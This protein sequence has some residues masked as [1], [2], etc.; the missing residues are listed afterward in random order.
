MLSAQAIKTIAGCLA[1]ILLML[2]IAGLSSLDSA[3][4]ETFSTI[5][6]GVVLPPESLELPNT[7]SS[8]DVISDITSAENVASASEIS[9][10]PVE[11]DY[12]KIEIKSETQVA[13]KNSA[14]AQKEDP[15]N[16]KNNMGSGGVNNDSNRRT[17]PLLQILPLLRALPFPHCPLSLKEPER[18]LHSLRKKL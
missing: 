8:S 4:E 15:M 18:L 10:A 6:S 3:A 13:G 9:S 5:F 16:H 7:P 11:N 14:T 1:G 17:R 12:K 2:P